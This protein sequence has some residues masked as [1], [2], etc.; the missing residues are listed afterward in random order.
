MNAS[1]DKSILRIGLYFMLLGVI[2]SCFIPLFLSNPFTDVGLDLALPFCVILI[3]TPRLFCDKKWASVL[4]MIS[5]ILTTL[6]LLYFDGLAI[7]L[8]LTFKQMFFTIFVTAIVLLN[9]YLCYRLFKLLFK[10]Q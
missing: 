2:C 6:A 4:L 8:T 3:C 9:C 5:A 1:K 10:T 7:L